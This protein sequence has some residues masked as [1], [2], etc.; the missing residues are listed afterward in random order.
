MHGSNGLPGEPGQTGGSF[1]VRI[2]SAENSISSDQL[3]IDVRGGK[4]GNGQNGGNGA[5]GRNG[6]D[7]PQNADLYKDKKCLVSRK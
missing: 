2:F 3:T 1:L 5:D 4:G 7:A 6:I